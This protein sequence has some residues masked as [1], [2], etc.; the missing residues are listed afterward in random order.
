VLHREQR[1]QREVDRERFPQRPA[2]ID[3]GTA[4]SPTKPIA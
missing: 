4:T 2:S 1:Q 3:R